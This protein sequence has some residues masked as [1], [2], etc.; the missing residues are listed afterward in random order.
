M[1]RWPD[2]VPELSEDR[3]RLRAHR[4]DD[5]DAI[6]EMCRDPVTQRWTSNLPDPYEPPHAELFIHDRVVTGWQTGTGRGWA[7]EAVDAD[8]IPRYAGNVDVH[9]GPA[10]EIGFLLH[11]W[12]RGQGVVSAAARLVLQWCFAEAGIEMVTWASQV[13]NVASRRVA[14]ATGFTF[15]GT[16]PRVLGAAGPAVDGWIATLVAGADSR[17]KTRWLTPTVMRGER[18]R[19]RPFTD[20]DIPRIIEACSDARSRHWLS[21]LPSPYTEESARGVLLSSDFE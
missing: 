20:A 10:A 14:W 4:D 21:A 16:M 12:A 19:L 11:P 13:G 1:F 15:H 9:G 5:L 8:G 2:D 7:I 18:V 3:V 17:P 6:V